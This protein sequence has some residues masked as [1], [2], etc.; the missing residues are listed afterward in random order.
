MKLK[1]IAKIL[2]GFIVLIIVALIAIPF[3]ISADYLKSQLVTQVKSATGRDLVIKGKTSLKLF[4]NIAVSAEDVTFS[5]PE[6]FSSPY[7]LK[8]QKLETGAALKP[9]LS[10]ELRI[11]GVTLVGAVINLE[12]NAAG[13]KNWEFASKNA[14]PAAKTD[15]TEPKKAGGSPLKGFAIGDI[16]VKD[17]AFSFIKAGSPTVGATDINL[18]LSGADG[19]KALKLDG[20]AVYQQQKVSAKVAVDQM[21][22]LMAGKKSPVDVSVTV[23]SG[24][25]SFKGNASNDKDIVVDGALNVS[26]DS[27]PTLL[28]WATSKPVA[29]GLP[30]KFSLKTKLGMK[31][32]QAI[33][34]N[35]LALSVDALST[36]GKLGIN[37]GEAVPSVRGAL[38][39]DTL[40]VDAL[41]GDKQ[42]SV[43]ATPANNGAA[44]TGGNV[45]WSDERIDLSAL[46]SANANLD[47]SIN[48]LVSGK[49]EVTDIASNLQLTN[50]IMKLTLNNASLYSG[51]AQGTVAVDGSASAIRLGTNLNLVN[52]QI[53]PLMTALSG[54][55][56]LDGKT[57]LKLVVNGQGASQRAIVNT[58]AGN[59]SLQVLD[60]ALKGIN[61]ASFLRDA[62]KGFLGS[63]SNEKTDFSE[64]SATFQI[65]Q[66]IVTNNDLSMK[67]P[68]LRV[69]GKGTISLPPKTVN[70]RLEPTLVASLKGQGGKEK[71]GLTI[72]LVIAG[73]WSNPS[74]TPDVAGML[75]DSLQNPEALK[76]NLKDIKGQLKNLN[77]P[78]DIGK[79]LLG[80]G[81]TAPVTPEAAPAA[82]AASGNSPAT[83]AAE[84][85][86]KQKRTQAIQQGIGGLLNSMEKKQ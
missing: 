64:L 75:Q 34:L 40:D 39:V 46:R 70:Y 61:I 42:S 16:L 18:T 20:S 23:P 35:D 27:I 52:I 31:G 51:K 10:K 85:T 54:A 53:D 12:Q 62:K 76:E 82:A 29:A 60:G 38:H 73:P 66:G 25:V 14:E 6:G 84:P 43:R 30:K 49:I 78:K 26:I 24:S 79:A 55:S 65:A 28:S 2:V 13:A 32:T 81:K 57:N 7:M 72:P 74:I 19:S 56:R 5:N 33:A 21:K 71:A 15:A 3:F 4:P 83:P 67:S 86:A 77:S 9:L 80:D 44:A 58:L 8:L 63:S 68:V 41:T 17:S 69:G 47:L 45:G 37:L 36:T 59:A 48:K 50:G 22:A 1:K 11:T